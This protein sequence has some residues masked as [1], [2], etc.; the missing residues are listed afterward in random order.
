MKTNSATIDR[1]C[2]QKFQ[3]IFK[4][5][6]VIYQLWGNYEKFLHFALAF[7]RTCCYV[8]SVFWSPKQKGS[9]LTTEQATEVWQAVLGELELQLPR[10]A[11]ETWL[12]GTNG[13]SL[14]GAVLQV[15]VPSPFVAEC[16]EKR[17]YQ[18][19][20]KTVE[21]VVSEPLE[22]RFQVTDFAP[23]GY[24]PPVQEDNDDGERAT[25]SPP[26]AKLNSHYT[27]DTFVVGPSNRLAYS[28]ALAVSEAPGSSYNPLFIYSGVGLGKTHLLHAIAH[29]CVAKKQRLIYVTGEQFTNEFIAA[30]QGRTTEQF[31]HKFR[32]PDVLLIDDIH[33]I[34]GK[35]QTQEGFFH[36]FNELHT[37][38]RQIIL[39][40]DRPPR[41]LSLLEDR[42]RSR[43]EWGLIA[44]IQAP[45][46]ETRMVIL[47]TKAQQMG[48]TLEEPVIELIAKKVRRN[49]RELEGSL[50]RILAIAQL[51][52]SPVT[53]DMVSRSLADLLTEQWRRSIE[54]E[55]I[56]QAVCQ[57]FSVSGDEILGRRRT[58]TIALARQIAMFLLREEL[59]MSMTR[60]GRFMGGKDHTTVI[61]AVGNI[62]YQINVDP[63]LNQR[64]L[65]IKEQLLSPATA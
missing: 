64:V 7:S 2:K 10:H 32:S 47:N 63:E 23:A 49:V 6:L 38:G 60:I 53:V 42:L 39:T 35:E 22:V 9:V 31:R 5:T 62:S 50:N 45:D 14:D 51:T 44:D 3:I 27:F 65:F 25:G 33:F 24:T 40:S 19:I 56:L 57:Q 28:A 48:H 4:K 12:K 11:Y 43:F 17:M 21:R 34:S 1:P 46:L 13:S 52:G 37:A 61:H 16:L 41:S 20:H 26:R 18:L 55:H 36:T 8:A 15:S 29:A 59:H 30:I 54:P 58:K